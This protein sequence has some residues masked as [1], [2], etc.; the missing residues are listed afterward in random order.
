MKDLISGYNPDDANLT[1]LTT[2]NKQMELLPIQTN[3]QLND[4]VN[5]N[6]N[7]NENELIDPLAVEEKFRI[8]RKKL[9]SML[10]GEND[11]QES[12]ENF[13]QRVMRETK[14]TVIWPSKLKIGAKSK[15]DPHV[16]VL[17]HPEQVKLAKEKIMANLD[18]KRSKICL[19]ID[20]SYPDH[21]HL[22]GKRGANIQEIMNRTRCQIHFP[23]SNRNNDRDKS[24]Q[25]SISG[26]PTDVEE[27]RL[28]I[29]ESLPLTF[30]FEVSNEIALIVDWLTVKTKAKERYGV[31]V[32]VCEM[33]KFHPGHSR[34]FR[35]YRTMVTSVTVKGCERQSTKATECCLELLQEI[36]GHGMESVPVSV[37]MDIAPHHHDTVLRYIKT[38]SLERLTQTAIV[39]PRSDTKGPSIESSPVSITGSVNGVYCA[40]KAVLKWLPAL[41]TFDLPEDH[42]ALRQNLL[43]K[44]HN[45]IEITT[46]QKPRDGRVTISLKGVEG[47]ILRMYAAREKV[48]SVCD[49]SLSYSDM[50]WS[51]AGSK[52]SFDL[53]NGSASTESLSSG[54]SGLSL[55]SSFT[56]RGAAPGNWNALPGS[57]D[58]LQT[59][60]PS[61]GSNVFDGRSLFRPQSHVAS[62][63]YSGPSSITSSLSSPEPSPRFGTP[64]EFPSLQA[65]SENSSSLDDKNINDIMGRQCGDIP[66][67]STPG[68]QFEGAIYSSIANSSIASCDLTSDSQS[69]FNG[70]FLTTT[71][72]LDETLKGFPADYDQKRF[73]A[74]NG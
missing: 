8:D 69:L 33:Q 52:K 63:N 27:A 16:K 46:K 45:G 11:A 25:V 42:N 12:A 19:K 35:N 23:D 29:R 74:A 13:F 37:V 20:V 3:G 55:A 34:I 18:V 9:E 48:L 40:W 1:V 41:I 61:V 50:S 5:I 21:S 56:K 39:F 70:Q 57:R 10:Q 62:E 28:L 64:I 4:V 24:N 31:T 26:L 17:G 60:M 58:W 66:R 54:F 2:G 30:K 73:L 6:M 67:T 7:K 47:E 14:A 51:T 53:A 43:P 59:Q 72:D 36:Y 22:I 44:E 68:L 71:T 49:L 38:N 32:N 65:I 15:K